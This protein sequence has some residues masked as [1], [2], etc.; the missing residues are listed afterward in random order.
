M[1]GKTTD[2]EGTANQG[3]VYDQKTALAANRNQMA[4]GVLQPRRAPRMPHQSE[5]SRAMVLALVWGPD[6]VFHNIAQ[7]KGK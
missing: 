3:K 2:S 1:G 4:M 6:L 7:G 5:E